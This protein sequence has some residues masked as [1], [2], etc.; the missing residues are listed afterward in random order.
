MTKKS[1]SGDA[2][3]AAAPQTEQR[4]EFNRILGNLIKAG[5]LKRKDA[6]T[7]KKNVKCI[8]IVVKA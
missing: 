8:I 6:Q 5:P 1:D 3:S 4:D 2:K 7:G